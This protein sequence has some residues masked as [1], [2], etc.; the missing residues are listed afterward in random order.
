M[1]KKPF[2][3]LDKIFIALLIYNTFFLFIYKKDINMQKRLVVLHTNRS[4]LS[5]KLPVDYPFK[6]WLCEAFLKVIP[7]T[8]QRAF[9]YHNGTRELTL[10]SFSFKS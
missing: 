9:L 2:Q 6:T 7:S 10:F 5:N 8:D 4:F 3:S 1:F